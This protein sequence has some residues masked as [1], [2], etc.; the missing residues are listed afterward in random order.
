MPNFYWPLDGRIA[1]RFGDWD[2]IAA[3]FK[4]QRPTKCKRRKDY[5]LNWSDLFLSDT[6]NECMTLVESWQRLLRL[7]SSWAK[8]V[9]QIL[10]IPT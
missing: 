7:C 3:I 4:L 8:H 1:W 5:F 6:P 10:R 2:P 9:F